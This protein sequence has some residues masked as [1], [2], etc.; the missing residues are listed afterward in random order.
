MIPANS[1]F[2]LCCRTFQ[3]QVQRNYK[4]RKNFAGS[5]AHSFKSFAPPPLSKNSSSAELLSDSNNCFTFV[6]TASTD[7]VSYPK[8]MM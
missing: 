6:L 2:E 8:T 7:N 3:C 5:S 4:C 1:Y